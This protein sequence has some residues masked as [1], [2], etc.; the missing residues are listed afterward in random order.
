MGLSLKLSA[1]YDGNIKN[2]VE[3]F[4]EL[5]GFCSQHKSLNLPSTQCAKLATEVTINGGSYQDLIAPKFK[6]LI[7]FLK[8][9]KSGPKL[10]LLKSISIAKE[11]ILYGEKATENFTQAFKFA[12]SKDGLKYDHTMAMDFA[13]KLAK[14]SLN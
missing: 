10:P 9:H 14:R 6:E 12:V 1:K 7:S 3:N 11:I 2:A 13:T 8:E 4:K 5:V